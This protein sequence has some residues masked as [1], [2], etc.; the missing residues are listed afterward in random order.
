MNH[1]ALKQCLVRC[2]LVLPVL[3]FLPLFVVQIKK[4]ELPKTISLSTF[5]REKFFFFSVFNNNMS[6]FDNSYFELLTAAKNLLR[7]NESI[8]FHLNSEHSNSQQLTTRIY[9]VFFLRPHSYPIGESLDY[10]NI[11]FK[12]MPQSE[13]EEV[14]F[15]S[16]D[17]Q[18][19]LTRDKR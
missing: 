9:G 8:A 11:Y 13:N 10:I 6:H 16:D 5:E 12:R 2:I 1:R 3:M 15:M 19:F 14:L 4:L 7:K 18:S 17:R